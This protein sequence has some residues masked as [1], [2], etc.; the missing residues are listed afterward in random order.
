M[1]VQLGD[2]FSGHSFES[3]LEDLL[4]RFLL[5]VP[6][7]DL[8]SIER[9]FFQVE[10]AHW[11]YS[12]LVRNEVV[13]LPKI[14]MKQFS[15]KFLEKCPLIWKWGD[16]SE[17]IARFGQYK[18]IIPVRGIA[19]FNKSLTKVV[20]VKGFESN[21]W[22]FP[23]GKISKNETDIDCAIREVEEETGFNAKGL[24]NKKEYI[25]KTIRGK[26]YKIYLVSDV[27]ESFNFQPMV[28]NEI[29]E[30]SWH[31]IETLQ[32]KTR[33]NSNHFFIVSTM[34]DTISAWIAKKHKKGIDRTLMKEVERALKDF[35][36]I[37]TNK[38]NEEQELLEIL[39]KVPDGDK[40]QSIPTAADPS[41]MYSLSYPNAVHSSIT[42]LNL[43][44]NWE[45]NSY[46]E[47]N[48]RIF[49]DANLI[50]SKYSE[51]VYLNQQ[52]D[53]IF[54]QKP[55]LNSKKN[56]DK[57][58]SKE[59]LSMLNEKKT[60]K[61][62]GNFQDVL[63]R[64]YNKKAPRK[65]DFFTDSMDS[66]NYD[67]NVSKT[68]LEILN[69]R[70]SIGSKKN[71]KDL[72]TP[73]AKPCN[74]DVLKP[75]QTIYQPSNELEESL[76]ESIRDS[77]NRFSSFKNID[78]NKKLILL[79]RTSQKNQQEKLKIESEKFLEILNN[80]KS[81]TDI[82]DDFAYTKKQEMLVQKSISHCI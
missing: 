10:E 9:I 73:V 35:L 81:Q 51:Y 70:S 65:S 34:L 6:D 16:P 13:D 19:L 18:S 67:K 49:S 66:K 41:T 43:S 7:E 31:E 82:N 28:K 74:N 38:T 75:K 2:G 45:N 47:S 17:S 26:N 21:T 60:L 25:E 29:A 3:V 64:N 59:L 40:N 71:E 79:K 37:V 15:T 46:V 53:P 80:P 20:L 33:G 57:L 36:G 63:I 23:R 72:K 32:R 55:S 56:S 78:A 4:V 22:S 27:S 1:S 44:T 11:F 76:R 12:D 77:S 62:S 50:D 8:S 48:T 54:F 61:K 14:N 5:N 69:N 58:N 42:N 52:P 39:G 30:I 68:L 24:I